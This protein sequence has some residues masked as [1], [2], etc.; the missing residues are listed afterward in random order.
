MITVHLDRPPRG[1]RR[2][3]GL[4]SEDLRSY[5]EELAGAGELL[6]VRAPLEL[7]HELAAALSL[8]EDGP[9]A[10]FS[11]VVDAGMPIV[12]NVVNSR[13]RIARAL[14]VGIEEIGDALL[15]SIR[16][17]T[18]TRTVTD[19]AVG[20]IVEPADLAALPVPEFFARE[21]GPYITA[22]VIVAQD[23]LTGERNLSFAR[24]KVLGPNRAMLGVSPNHHLGQM[25]RRA[26]ESGRDLPIA[27][28]IGVHPAIMLA[29]CLYLGFGDDELECAGALLGAPVD[30]VPTPEF[31][32]LVP[33]DAEIVLE[34]VVKP[35]ELIEEGLVSEFHGRYHDYGPGYAVDFRTTMRRAAPVLQ[36]IV[37]G[38]HR[39]HLLLGAVSIAAGMLDRLREIAPN[40]RDVAVPE[41][42]AGR[43]AIVVS[44]DDIQPGQ[45]A[46]IIDAGLST[47]KLIKQV[48]VVDSTVDPW[49]TDAVEWARLSH[50]RP[51]RDFVI[52]PDR[53][54]D[55]SDPLARGL[56]LGKIGVDATA[57]P[58]E[59]EEG[60]EFAA[61]P[62]ESRQRAQE[63]L[64]WEGI[65]PHPSRLAAGLRF[66]ALG[67][68]DGA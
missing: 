30:V 19:A 15:R 7:R 49:N 58:G 24:F 33:A 9:A 22:G 2:E 27:V 37:P 44:V 25:A 52:L 48:I 43:T 62:F 35:D 42:G 17:P 67:D 54:T 14:G 21:S 40:V 29:A 10:W 6:S 65:S 41:P 46:T 68:V 12:G 18:P 20:E 34:G 26:A 32:L 51:E 31:G 16:T 38:L 55:R 45:A 66:D 53:R 3:D 60:W 50:A 4:V 11:G 56:H 59:R 23:V 64:A 5:L 13:D 39:E 1:V 8:I 63:L 61:V 47:V 36:V 57:K 28:A